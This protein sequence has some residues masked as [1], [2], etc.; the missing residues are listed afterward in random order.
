MGFPSQLPIR[1]SL[2]GIAVVLLGWCLPT[3]A[4]R[5][6]SL[7]TS[8]DV[9]GGLNNYPVTT[10]A[11]ETSHS[12]GFYSLTPSASVTSRTARSS[13]T[14]GYTLGWS[15]YGGDQQRNSTSHSFSLLWSR[16]LGPRWS[17]RV[18][19]YYSL[20]SD[21][22][23]FYA[24]RGVPIEEDAVVLYFYPV[25]TNSRIASN[26]LSFGVDRTLSTRSSVS[27][28]VSHSVGFHGD[29]LSAFAGF[30]DLRTI[31]WN[32]S[33]SRSFNDRTSWNVGYSGS[34]FSFDK[35]NS[36]ISSAVTVGVTSQVAKNT[37]FNISAGPSRVNNLN[38]P[39][40]NSTLAASVGVTHRIK[41]NSF[42]FSIGNNNATTSGVGSVS[43][44][45]SAN[46]GV[47]RPLGR[48]VNVFGDFSAFDGTGIV[49]NPFNTR[50][51]S[52]TANMGYSLAKNLSIQ[53][54]FTFQ[55][56]IRP[57]PQAFSE[58]RLFVSLRYSHPSLLRSR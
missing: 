58:R 49:G 51:V 40:S 27:L 26:S 28:G 30:S 13:L 19:E 46:A 23:T 39:G 54:G 41:E 48:R 57:A 37:T 32:G 44:T 8:I 47:S 56:Y 10:V 50:G 14:F 42:H 21:L 16:Q 11:G 9:S 2:T 7:D 31:S 17:M 6:T 45:R 25:T 43:S 3:H 24:L 35:F 15:H 33:Y 29:D 53:G 18:G 20:S 4:Q 12:E 34:Y 38:L 22:R 55:R 5:V 1:V 36:A 52:A